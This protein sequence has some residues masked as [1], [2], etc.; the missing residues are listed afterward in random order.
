MDNLKRI[1]ENFEFNMKQ[2]EFYRDTSLEEL[3]DKVKD[4]HIDMT[5]EELVDV[6]KKFYNIFDASVYLYHQN[7]AKWNALEGKR[8]TINADVIEFLLDKMIDRNFDTET[9]CDPYYIVDRIKRME[10]WP[11]S[12]VQE[13]ILNLITS[14]V[15]YGERIGT[16]QCTDLLPEFQINFVL[17]RLIKKCH[18]RDM[19]FKEVMKSYYDAF[20]DAD[21]SI[22]KLK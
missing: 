15:E 11:K 6:Y 16:R 12:E 5:E 4:V 7:Q 10:E 3:L 19:H 9:L 1:A 21:R 22:Y 2:F 17:K 8:N 14:V 13:K 18:N 20:D